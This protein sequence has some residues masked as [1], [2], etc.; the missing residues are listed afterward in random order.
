MSALVR[1]SPPPTNLI[2][3]TT[4]FVGRAQELAQMDALLRG[5]A[6]SILVVLGAA[7]I[8]K[9]RLALEYALTRAAL[10]EGGAL[11]CELS[12]ARDLPAVCQVLAD[13]LGM[14][15]PDATS[16]GALRQIGLALAERGP[17]LLLL[18]NFEQL[19]EQSHVLAELAQTAPLTTL[20]VTSRV[21][22]GLPEEVVLSLGPLG[23][24]GVELFLARARQV[25]PSYSP[26]APEQEQMAALCRSLDGIPLAIELA[27]ARMRVMS[28]AQIESNLSR[29]FL[30]LARADGT[31]ARQSTLQRALDWSWELLSADEQAALAQSAVFRGGFALEA[32]ESV[33]QVGS[34]AWIP[35][36]LQ[37]LCD[38][39]LMWLH[40]P[41]TGSEPRF[42]LYTSVREYAEPRLQ[43]PELVRA[44]HARYFAEKGL[45]WADELDLQGLRTGWTR[46]R[47]EAENLL[48]AHQHAVQTE[49]MAELALGS[50]V[51]LGTL[52]AR[53]GS[54]LHYTELVSRSL[55][56]AEDAGV[57][58][59][60]IARGLRRLGDFLSISGQH[61]AAAAALQRA[62]ALAE[63]Q[64]PP[65]AVR[66]YVSLAKLEHRKARYDVV[67]EL[68]QR[69]L[70]LARGARDAHGELIVRHM[71][72]VMEGGRGDHERSAEHHRRA[73]ALARRLGDRHLEALSLSNLGDY[74]IER[75]ALA[76][77]RVYLTEAIEIQHELGETSKEMASLAGLGILALEQG[78]WQ[79]ARRHL[80]EAARTVAR[81][82][83]RLGQSS[84]LMLL[85]VAC[86]GEGALDEALLHYD[87]ALELYEESG[88][89]VGHILTLAWRASLRVRL[90]PHPQAARLDLDAA[91]QRLAA[92][93]HPVLEAMVGIMDGIVEVS[94]ARLASGPAAA[95]E[96]V[97]SLQARYAPIASSSYDVR[98]ALRELQHIPASAPAAAP[99]SAAL[100][101]AR[102]GLWFQAPGGERVELEQRRSLRLLLEALARQRL[103]QPDTPLPSQ[104]LLE[105]GWP[106]ERMTAEAGRTRLYSAIYSL[107]TLGLRTLLKK[108]DDGYLLDP[109]VA[110]RLQG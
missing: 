99:T 28:L 72:G 12:E 102:G 47:A 108:R 20:L 86:Q 65:V 24:E 6:A 57:S 88:T 63:R 89:P 95:A 107:R 106:G 90:G 18:D 71:Y 22:L 50:A 58:P 68:L 77:A 80:E 103:A 44:R 101:V 21:R 110:L 19:Q 54:R 76:E 23:E 14:R 85:G 55:S 1:F 100:V 29:R 9:T 59:A 15:L 84:W 82:G 27:A 36:V 109:S 7:G 93:P 33:L 46:L 2:A 41:G 5:D 40:D 52:Y 61:D 94:A 31:G 66:S 91:R 3:P 43:A 73:L 35:D 56:L 96:L 75:G 79:T 105:A 60:L 69:T 4:S 97:A 39:S 16:T 17:T 32:A 64:A 45:Q 70:A 104:A 38:Q 51:A 26:S 42:G 92:L 83:E 25:R 37:S 8:G 98:L 10:Y 11:F 53:D 49:A 74:E 81:L 30:L 13:A 34:G 48:A 62:V 78:D 87:R 67:E